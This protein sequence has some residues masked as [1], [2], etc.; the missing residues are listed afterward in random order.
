MKLNLGCICEAGGSWKNHTGSWRAFRP[1]LDEDKCI[2]CGIC[3]TYCPDGSVEVRDKIAV[4]NLKYCKGCG[5]CM[6]EC[7]R[8]AIRMVE[9]RGTVAN[10]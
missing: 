1:V 2:G 8:D 4:F 7:P 5:I 6:V 9:E 3:E 10:E